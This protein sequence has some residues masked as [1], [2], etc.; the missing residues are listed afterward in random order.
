MYEIDPSAGWDQASGAFN[1][2]QVRWLRIDWNLS[3]GA[4]QVA[5]ET[6]YLDDFKLVDPA[7][8]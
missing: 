7:S 2:N 5:G 8:P 4:G 1:I 6:L 3:E